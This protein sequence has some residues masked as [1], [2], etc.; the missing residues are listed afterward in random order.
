MATPKVLFFANTDWYLW[1]FRLPLIRALR[2][3]GWDVVLASPTGPWG[4]RLAREGF[5]W[6]P[7]DFARH[8]M[9]PA[10]EIATLLRLIRLYRR[11]R[12]DIAHH[13]TIKCVLYGGIAARFA[14]APIT[15]NAVTGLGSLFTTRG[16][17]SALLRPFV[18]WLYWHTFRGSHVIFQN[19]DDL[20]EFRAH[21]LLERAAI[22]LIRGSGVDVDLFT[23]PSCR[24]A[25]PPLIVIMVARLLREKGVCEF[26]AAAR[27]LRAEG[28]PAR[29][30]LV[31]GRDPEQPSAI[32]DSELTR[33]KSDGAVELLGHRDDVLDLLRS[34]HI[35]CLPSWREGTPRSLL[36]AMA[37]GLPLVATD[38]PGCREVVTDG[39]N[40]ILVPPRNPSV[41]ADALRTLIEDEQLRARMGDRSRERAC[42][43]F[44][45]KYVLEQTFE[46][47]RSALA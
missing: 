36:E 3:R 17:R 41:L 19:P 30:I 18:R 38:V 2:D 43:E 9:N 1:N 46:I 21:G 4:E 34:A 42:G 35:A 33:W 44:A 31:G 5:R 16:P 24:P 15:V 8:G 13:F 47:Y 28:L 12:P 26:V 11:E 20:A 29:F 45:Q 23:P 39:D 14:S 27:T 10:E 6:I 32:D 37:C 7:F 25:F 40:G 22:H